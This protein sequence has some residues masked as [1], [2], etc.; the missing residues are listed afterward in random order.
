MTNPNLQR[1]NDHLTEAL[2]LTSIGISLFDACR[3]LSIPWEVILQLRADDSERYESLLRKPSPSQ[4]DVQAPP[5]PTRRTTNKERHTRRA[6]G[7]VL[8]HYDIAKLGGI[9]QVTLRELIAW[10][11]ISIP[12]P[13]RDGQ[14]KESMYWSLDRRSEWITWFRDYH[15]AMEARP[16][17]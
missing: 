15:N 13:E 6:T 8:R 10:S 16:P 17:A 12:T 11:P 5:P 14:D 4:S 1:W 7:T 3:K 2:E 9:S